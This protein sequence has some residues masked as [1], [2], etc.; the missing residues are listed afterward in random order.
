MSATTGAVGT[1][2][3]FH[4]RYLQHNT[5]LAKTGNPATSYP[6]AD[7]EPHVSSPRTVGRAKH[8][9]D[10]SGLGEQLTPITARYASDDELATVHTRDYSSFH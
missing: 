5:G 1:G 9:L 6:Y 2:L 8:L 10:L 7:P 3:V 4:D